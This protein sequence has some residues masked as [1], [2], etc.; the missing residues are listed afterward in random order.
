M[1]LSRR[2]LLGTLLAAPLVVR[3]ASLMP[4]RM[5]SDDLLKTWIDIPLADFTAFSYLA[6][7]GIMEHVDTAKVASVRV[8][9]DWKLHGSFFDSSVADDWSMYRRG[10]LRHGSK[11]AGDTHWGRPKLDAEWHE[12][13]FNNDLGVKYIAIDD[14][15]GLCPIGKHDEE[16]SFF[17]EHW[18]QYAKSASEWADL[19]NPYLSE[20][21]AHLHAEP[22]GF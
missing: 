15:G 3:A 4:V 9:E 21:T 13:D 2:T 14:A 1:N 12:G 17:E 8:R 18:E 5:L 6:A 11:L 20:V 7:N 16:R 22:T 19:N 10:M